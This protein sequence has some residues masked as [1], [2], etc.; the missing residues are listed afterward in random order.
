M[1]LDINELISIRHH[2]HRY[3]ELSTSEQKTAEFITAY[4]T[5]LFPTKL[6]TGI[7]GFGVVACFDSNI[8]G[9]SISFRAELDALPSQEAKDLEYSSENNG[10][11]HLC[12]HD[13]HAV[14]LLG[15]GKWQ[16]TIH[17]MQGRVILVFHPAEETAEGQS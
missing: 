4:L 9:K 15:L 10:V 13:G 17:K 1:K 12:G 14:I 8:K 5:K 16:R 2:L 11:A 6:I 3:P 7:G